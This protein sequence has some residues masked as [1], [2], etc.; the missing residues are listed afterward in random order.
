MPAL[1]PRESLRVVAGAA[2]LARHAAAEVRAHARSA[3]AARGAFHLA[4]AGG[5]TPRAA[6]RDLARTPD[7]GQKREL[8]LWHL[9][10]GD[11]RCVPPADAASNYRMVEESGL[12]ARVASKNVHRLRGEAPDARAEAARYERELCT[13]LGN[14]PRLDLVLL[15]LGADGHTASLFA[16]TP[17]LDERAWVTLGHAPQPPIERLTLTLDTLAQARA[18]LFLVAGADKRAALARAVNDSGPS[19]VPAR[20][21]YPLE[22]SLL[23]IVERAAQPDGAGPSG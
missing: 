23:W 7:D 15:G 6:Y 11:E 18:L 14:P 5:S 8:A 20:R 10:F 13:A 4:L 16:G 2:E 1:R 9:W 19:P 3:V 21:A 22:G 12:L 17:S